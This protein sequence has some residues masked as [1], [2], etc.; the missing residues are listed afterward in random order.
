MILQVFQWDKRRF[1]G[2][3]RI[4]WAS[5]GPKARF[6]GGPSSNGQISLP[7]AATASTAAPA[8]APALQGNL[9]L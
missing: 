2:S 8:I 6:G 9:E 7:L 5:H 4:W 1:T 3:G